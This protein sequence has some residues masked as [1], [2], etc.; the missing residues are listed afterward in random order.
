[1]RP[2]QGVAGWRGPPR[3]DRA[4]AE[5]SRL[6]RLASLAAACAL[7]VVLLLMLSPADVQIAQPRFAAGALGLVMIQE[8]LPSEPSP[9]RAIRPRPRDGL[10]KPPS[11]RET[12]ALPAAVIA[13]PAD[14][15]TA[16]EAASVT[17][18]EPPASAPLRLHG[19]VLRQAAGESK[20]AV[21]QMADASG[22]SPDTQRATATEKLAADIERTGKPDCLAPGSGNLLEAVA[23]AYQTATGRCKID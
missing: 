2:M 21:Q 17:A 9:M 3:D 15:P 7:S 10:R 13:L 23:R 8:P 16:A 4:A 14:P 20:S 19:S 12:A 18:P 22:Q 5:P 6:S 11:R 1:M